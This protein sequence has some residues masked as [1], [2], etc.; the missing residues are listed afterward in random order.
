M[1]IVEAMRDRHLFAASFPG[2]SWLPWQAL[3]SA[4]WGLD[5]TTPVPS[6]PT[7]AARAAQAQQRAVTVKAGLSPVDAL[8]SPGRWR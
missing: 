3:L 4:V 5:L 7:S 2:D 1:D 8:A 6:K